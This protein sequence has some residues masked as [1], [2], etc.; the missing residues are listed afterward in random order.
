MGDERRDRLDERVVLALL[1]GDVFVCDFVVFGGRES[2][3]VDW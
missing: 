1:Y 2:W 3:Q